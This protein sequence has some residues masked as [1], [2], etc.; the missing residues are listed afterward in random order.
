VAGGA[1]AIEAAIG[2]LF[3]DEDACHRVHRYR[4]VRREGTAIDVSFTAGEAFSRLR[5]VTPAR[6]DRTEQGVE[7]GVE[8]WFVRRGVPHLIEDYAPTTDIWN[9]SIPLLVLAYVAGGFNA[10][11]LHRWTWQRNLVVV[12]VIVVVLVGGGVVTNLLRHRAPWSVPTVVGTPELALVVVGPALPSL[13]FGQPGDALQTVLEGLAVLA[14]IYLVTSYAVFALVRWAARRSIAQIA[15]LASLVARALPLLLLFTAFLFISTEV[16][17]VAGSL[18]GMPYAA[19]LGIFFLLGALFVLIRVPG[20]LRGL[21]TF[22]DWTEVG[23]AIADTPAA[24]LDVPAD[25]PAIAAPLSVRQRL[26][27]GLVTVFSQALQVSLVSLVLALF[28]VV[29]GFL[30]IPVE[31]TAS[32]T[33]LR[34]VHTLLTWH[35]DGRDLVITEPLL[36]VAGFLGAFTGM[37]FT[38]VLSTDATYRDEFAEDVGPQIRQAL[39]V[40]IAYLHHRLRPATG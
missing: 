38:V 6:S 12:L 28:F 24:G 15:S 21:G 10:L 31:T 32:W 4:H 36:R 7:Q 9:R 5:Q 25:G 11:D 14:V 34:E 8:Q 39:A 27:V 2:D 35:L 23:L 18:T 13:A 20:T 17:Q 29:F 3:G 37:Y 33:G 1:E 40:R 16:W 22:A 26:N 19:T 30:A